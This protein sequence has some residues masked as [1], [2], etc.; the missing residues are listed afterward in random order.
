MRRR[1]V[2]AQLVVCTHHR[3]PIENHQNRLRHLGFVFC[4]PCA[5][6]VGL[7]PGFERDRAKWGGH[8]YKGPSGPPRVAPANTPG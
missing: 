2:G 5:L 6:I 4:E 7:A 1:K 3:G 8:E